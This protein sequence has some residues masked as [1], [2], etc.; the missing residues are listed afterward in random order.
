MGRR[1]WRNHKFMGEGSNLSMFVVF[2]FSF[3]LFEI[4]IA[5]GSRISGGFEFEFL[6]GGIDSH[7]L[8]E[9]RGDDG[10]E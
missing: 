6:L 4:L 7:S 9:L 1:T 5:F 3:E 8:M 2:W 10:D